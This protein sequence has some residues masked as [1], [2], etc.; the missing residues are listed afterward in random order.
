MSKVTDELAD[1]LTVAAS[2]VGDTLSASGLDS[3]TFAFTLVLWPIG[4]PQ[5]C[6]T[7]TGSGHPDGQGE[8]SRALAAASEKSMGVPTMIRQHPRPN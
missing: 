4:K 5:R 6:S 1:I 2:V 7:I 8:A 3:E